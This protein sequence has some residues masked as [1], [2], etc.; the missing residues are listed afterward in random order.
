MSEGGVDIHIR[1]IKTIIFV[2]IRVGRTAR[3]GRGGVSVSL[4]GEQERSL[5]KDVIKKATNP[6]KRRVIAPDIIEK[7]NK[8]LQ[9]L[10]PDVEQIIQEERNEKELSKIENQANRIEKLL[11]GEDK[12]DG[13]VWFQTKKERKKEKG[14]VKEISKIS[15]F[16]YH[17]LIQF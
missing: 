8:E 13:R 12:K 11:K 4:A 7:Y 14:N 16:C 5:V 10:E 6:V 15:F 2:I 1:V 17:N 9:S 3:A